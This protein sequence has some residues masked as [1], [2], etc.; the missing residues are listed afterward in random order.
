LTIDINFAGAAGFENSTIKCSWSLDFGLKID[1]L[2][3]LLSLLSAFFPMIGDPIQK[4]L[5]MIV[6]FLT[7]IFCMPI[8]FI[9]SLLGNPILNKILGFLG[10]TLKDI[11]LPDSILELLQL[12]QATFNLRTLVLKKASGEWLDLAFGLSKQGNEFKGLSQFAALCNPPPLTNV[13]DKTVD[14]LGFATSD[15][16]IDQAANL[17]SDL[18]VKAVGLAT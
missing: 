9:E 6:D 4:F 17:K 14:V 18:L 15:L 2:A 7:K 5:K 12:L 10:C 11:K 13:I 1:L 8:N 16:P 3:L